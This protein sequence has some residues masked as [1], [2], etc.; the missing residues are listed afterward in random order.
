MI[1]TSHMCK[2]GTF[3]NEADQ[4]YFINTF[5]YDDCV[6]NVGPMIKKVTVVFLVI[7]STII[8]GGQSGIIFSLANRI[9]PLYLRIGS[10][11]MCSCSRYLSSCSR[12]HTRTILL[13]FHS[14]KRYYVSFSLLLS[15]HVNCCDIVK[16]EEEFRF[17]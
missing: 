1:Y 14:P 13:E 5:T 16:A 2:N 4:K 15:S 11:T 10:T 3:L 8:C 9:D 7:V 12:S 6:L 17:V